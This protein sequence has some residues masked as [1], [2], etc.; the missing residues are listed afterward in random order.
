MSYGWWNFERILFVCFCP[1]Y[2][3]QRRRIGDECIS[4]M[5]WVSAKGSHIVCFILFNSC[6]RQ[7]KCVSAYSDECIVCTMHMRAFHCSIEKECA[8]STQLKVS[9]CNVHNELK[10]WIIL[11]ALFANVTHYIEPSAYIICMG[12]EQIH[13]FFDQTIERNITEWV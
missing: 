5:T 10:H 1:F 2:T 8:T 4:V 11:V 6:C 13:P 12:R 3:H 9:C 7:A